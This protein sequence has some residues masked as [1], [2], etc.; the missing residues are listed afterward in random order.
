MDRT[1]ARETAEV[2]VKKALA[3]GSMSAMVRG[4]HAPGTRLKSSCHDA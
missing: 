3:V 1:K 4:W 2:T